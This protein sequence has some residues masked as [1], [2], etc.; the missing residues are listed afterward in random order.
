[1]SSAQK[2]QN[3]PAKHH[4]FDILSTMADD[5][6]IIKDS[7]ETKTSVE[8]DKVELRVKQL[9]DDALHVGEPLPGLFK[10]N[11][12]EYLVQ[13]LANPLPSGFK[14]LDASH[15][16]IIYWCV[17]ALK[18]LKADIDQTTCKAVSEHILSYV[19]TVGGGIGGGVGQM[20]HAAATYAGVCALALSQDT[21]LWCKLD[22]PAIYKWL[23]S[24]KTPENSFSMHLGGESDTRAV[25]CVL[26]VASMLDILTLELAEGVL[27]WLQSCQT[28]E[29]GFGGAP[30]DEAHGGYTFCAVAALCILGH[31]L[32]MLAKYCDL[33]Q[34]V[35]WTASRQQQLEGGFSGRTNKLVDG[36]YSHWVGG[37]NA[38][39]GTVVGA[40]VVSRLALNNYILICCQS[41]EFLGLVDK[42][43][44]SADFY[45]TN[46]VLCG[47]SGLQYRYSLVEEEAGMDSSVYSYKAECVEGSEVGET[48]QVEAL[49]PV[50]GVPLGVAEKMKD[51]Y[52]QISVLGG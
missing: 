6:A 36:C 42:P 39:L 2:F 18:L 47:L 20:G 16:W 11:H 14:V 44:K 52:R 38:L 50:L 29:G 51:F 27:E 28:Y 8:Q 10:N 9:Y 21:V 13:V 31:P 49:N 43:G 41:K 33:E 23:L 35:A 30:Y 37:L 46:Y 48:D 1:M 15:P 4:R 17:N 19:E 24:L 3:F 12:I 7:L 5:L 26:S 22:R 34:L 45:H 32:E 25:Y 40:D